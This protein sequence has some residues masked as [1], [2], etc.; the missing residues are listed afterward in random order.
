MMTKFS[1]NLKELFS[2]TRNERIAVAVLFVIL[3]TVFLYPYVVPKPDINDDG[4]EDFKVLVDEFE[5]GKVESEITKPAI[6]SNDSRQQKQP[7]TFEFDPNTAD[8]SSFVRLGFSQKQADVIINYR[9]KGGKFKTAD[10]FKKMYVVDEKNFERLQPYIKI[11]QQA[12]KPVE[13][14]EK[15]D[16]STHNNTTATRTYI[17][18]EINSADTAELKKL[19]GIGSYYA[20][21]IVDYRSKL[22]GFADISQLKEIRRI[23]DE[24]IQMFSNQVKIDTLLINKL[25][26]NTLTAKE[27]S[28]HP[29]IDNYTARGIVQYRDFAG[30]IENLQQLVKEKILTV[31]QAEKLKYYIKF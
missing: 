22:G 6:K 10:D 28:Q 11:K 18:V 21:L 29:Y 14:M 30:R 25:N 3:M 27:L 26:I 2:F 4:F 17:F 16:Y 19:H 20:R 5:S 13:N 24:R 12:G 7:E 31:E 8:E 9:N 15:S 1:K 23:D